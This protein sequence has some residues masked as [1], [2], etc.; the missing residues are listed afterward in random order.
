MRKH[1]LIAGILIVAALVFAMPSK[2]DSVSFTL[3]GGA[4]A[5]SLTF[6][7]PQTFTPTAGAGS[8]PF[9]FANVTAVPNPGNPIFGSLQFTL[10]NIELGVSATNQ[11]SFGSNGVPGFPGTTGNF[12][13]IFAPGLF[14]V[15]AD[16]TITV[17]DVG[18]LTVVNNN[19]ASL[20]LNETIIP[21]PVGTP[22][23]AT[24]ALL[25]IGGLALAGIRRRK[26]A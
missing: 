4:L 22:E 8:G 11:W 25:G 12:L 26:A 24:L 23:P 6:S 10:P 13:G 18:T 17:N 21:G 15:N 19:G 5:G 1:I 20:A 3:T 14:T 9:L 2:A 7:L 16:G